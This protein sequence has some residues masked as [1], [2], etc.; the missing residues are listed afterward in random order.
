M[1][2]ESMNLV[3]IITPV[4]NASKYLDQIFRC[5]QS[6]S[7]SD[8]EWLAVDDCSTDDSYNILQ[9][10]AMMDSRVN[11][12]K[13]NKNSGPSHSRNCGLDHAQGEYIAFLDADDLW[14]PSKLERQILFM[15]EKGI[16][17]SC[18]DYGII[19]DSGNPIKTV[20]MP[21][22]VTSKELEAYNPLATSFIMIKK[23]VLNAKKFDPNLRRR[24]DWVFWYHIAKA[25][26]Q[27]ISLNENLGK[28]RKD[29][30]HSI[31]RNKFYMAFIQWNMY[32]TYF[33]QGFFRSLISFIRYAFY[34]TTKHYLK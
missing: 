33:H 25:G 7:H 30:V 27:C 4:F 6:Q 2:G 13:N 1:C 16:T 17:F 11:I 5:L 23:S 28:Y 22:V 31:S 15:Q 29:S 34:G 12:F 21:V 19:S 18:H 9:T 3:S 14:S 32:R 24:Q 26:N 8:W 20:H 10:C